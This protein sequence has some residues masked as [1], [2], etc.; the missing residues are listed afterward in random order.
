MT[1]TNIQNIVKYAIFAGLW[2]ILIIPFIVTNGMFFPYITGKNFTFRIIVELIFALWIYLACVDKKYRP[3]CSW[4]SRA[5]VLFVLV[6]GIADIFAVAPMKAF[7]SNFERMDG[8]ITLIHL[9][10]YLFVFGAMMKTEKIWTWFFRTSIFLSV[11]MFVYTII[12][13]KTTGV[14]RVSTTLGNPIYVAIYFLFN[15][16]FTLILFYKDILKKHLDKTN[17]LKSICK[18][19]LTYV[20]AIIALMSIYGIWRTGTRGVLLGLLGGIVVTLLFISIFEKKNKFFRNSAIAKLILVVLIIGGFFA[21]ENTQFAKN[22]PMLSRLSEISWGNVA[23]QGQAR[24]YVWPMAIKGFLEKPI[25][26]WGQDGFNYVFN[27]YY[28]PR[29]HGQEEWFDRAHDM[30][31][32]MLVAGGALGLIS[33]LLI[34][35]ATLWLIWKKREKLGIVEAGILLGAIAGYFAQNLFV[36]DNVTS[37]IFFFVVLAYVHS[38]SVEDKELPKMLSG[39]MHSDKVNYLVVPLLVVV[40]GFSIWYFNVRPINANLDLIA[41]MQGYQEGP[42]KNLEFFKK[43]LSNGALGTP[44]IREQL[45]GLVPRVANMSGVDDKVKQ[46]F[47]DLA[48]SEMQ[49]QVTETPKDARYQLF[50][51]SFLENM[52]QYDLALPYLQKAVDLSPEKQTMLFELSKDLS[53]VGQKDQALAVAKKAYDLVPGYD[54]TRDNY[55][56]TAIMNDDNAVV[57]SLLGNATS[58]NQVIVRAYLFKASEFLKKGD[59]ASAVDEVN[60]AIKVVPLFKSQGA[61][62]IKGIWSGK[63]TG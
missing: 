13:W 11:I 51:G 16:F 60:Q 47:A 9:L 44:E 20:Y 22:S 53:Y 15:F 19:W 34:F 45:V 54:D 8:W 61:D 63:V 21:I 1:N 48:F 59:K 55:I 12:E 10:M 17:P 62:V 33:Y 58:S 52:G 4:V 32:D 57:E 38:I 5:V 3:K 25:L 24:Q 28:D 36:F 46:E 26:G 6:M 40:F 14:A 23:G 35:V 18:N 27:K 37:Y 7:W 39:E 41:G 42:S 43:A 31:L 30:P 2:A 49:K 56:A 29:M 50:M